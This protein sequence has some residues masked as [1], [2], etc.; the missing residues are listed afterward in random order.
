MQGVGPMQL[1]WYTT[2][3]AADARGGYWVPDRQQRRRAGKPS[4]RTSAP[5]R[6]SAGIAAYNGSGAA[7]TASVRKRRDRWHGLLT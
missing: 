7:A 2:Q 6:E 3:D 5:P 4:P 1:T